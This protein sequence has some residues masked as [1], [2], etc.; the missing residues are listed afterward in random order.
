MLIEID[1]NFL[2]RNNI[3]LKQFLVCYLLYK[4]ANHQLIKYTKFDSID[5]EFMNKLVDEGWITSNNLNSITST[6][7]TNKF[8]KLFTE[9]DYFQE[10]LD[11]FPKDVLRQDG[12]KVYLRT[13]QKDC[14]RRYARIIKNSRLKH[15]TIINALK[16]EINIR[17]KENKMMWFKTLP[18]WLKA[19]EWQIYEG[20]FEDGVTLGENIDNKYGT[21][22]L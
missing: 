8:S 5:L 11:T 1:T 10:L 14:K 7:V 13:A 22:I 19:E 2:I 21:N 3:N 18:N 9:K 15:D 12:S 20:I 4:G 17:T 6:K 16:A